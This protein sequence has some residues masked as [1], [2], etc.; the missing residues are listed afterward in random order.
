MVY[1]IFPL[2][3]SF[4]LFFVSCQRFTS[5]SAGHLGCVFTSQ[6]SDYCFG[7]VR[8]DALTTSLDG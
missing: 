8:A 3:I 7:G 2:S 1:L 5:S 6:F 4:V